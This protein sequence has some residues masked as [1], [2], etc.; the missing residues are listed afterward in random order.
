MQ[1]E[2]FVA[3]ARLEDRHWWFTGRRAILTALIHAVAPPGAGV[4]LVD[5]GCGTGGNAAALAREYRVLG[6]DPSADAV[7][8][9]RSRFPAVQFVQTDDPE[10]GCDHLAHGGVVILTDVL[11]HVADDRDLLAR[12][13]AVIPAGGHLI[14]TVPADSALW[15]RHDTQFGHYRRYRAGEL[16]AL[17]R[18][19]PVKERLLTPFNSRLRPVIATIRRF[20][21]DNGS[22]LRIPAGPLNA[23]L[24]RVF[25][26]EASALV[27]AIDRDR[28]A[29]SRGVSL[30][31]VLRKL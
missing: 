29:F 15:S 31:A 26:G 30:A 3:H 20:T 28:P 5:V 6:L 24:H 25:A 11:E 9:A 14:L 22:D 27:R 18:E 12:V 13:I 2:Q 17:W 8:L 19:A 7:A 21:R 1:H 4:A 23:V 10:S 16:R